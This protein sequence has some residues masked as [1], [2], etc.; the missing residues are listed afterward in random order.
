MGSHGNK[1][2]L[3]CVEMKLFKCTY[4]IDMLYWFVIFVTIPVFTFLWFI[5]HG[6]KLL[7]NMIWPR[8]SAFGVKVGFIISQIL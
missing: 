5:I 2:M 8:L 6:Q 4:L 3:G 1:R 7:T